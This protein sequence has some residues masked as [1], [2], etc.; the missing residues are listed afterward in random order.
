MDLFQAVLPGTGDWLTKSGALNK[1]KLVGSRR[2]R[3]MM[4]TVETI[5]VCNSEC[6]FCPYSIQT[7]T[8]GVMKQELFERVVQE[9]A[10]MGGGL[11]CVTPVVGDILLDR[12]LRE[13]LRFLNT[14]RETVEPTITTNLFALGRWDDEAVL[15][16]LTTLKKVHV[17]CYGITSE[18]SQQI[19]STEYF[20]EFCAQ[21]R[22]LLRIADA[23]GLSDKLWLGFRLLFSR[24]EQE[25]AEFQIANFNRVLPL[26]SNTTEYFNWGNSMRGT[27]PGEAY[28]TKSRENST[29]CAMLALGLLVFWDGR[30]SACLCC[31]YDA[32][33][34]LALGRI[35]DD[36]L[37]DLYNS[38]AN[39]QLWLR[40]QQGLLPP[41][42]KN[43][44]FHLPLERVGAH[45]VDNLLEIM[46]G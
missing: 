22:R 20:D 19:T 34:Q 9:Y 13:R 43:C 5:N 11:L 10:Q 8:K 46:G 15:Q 28:Y 30:V 25:L 4:L 3:P 2:M 39:Q 35:S 27:L 44:T 24:S 29:M 42:C 6:V 1:M 16:I 37:V 31:D 21:M 32:S 18:E 38:A 14:V 41:A 36:S 40:H 23:N 17:S 7:R 33:E 12:K 45:Q 26:S